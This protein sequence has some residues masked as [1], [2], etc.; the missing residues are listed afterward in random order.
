[1]WRPSFLTKKIL[2]RSQSHPLAGELVR[3]DAD[4]DDS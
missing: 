2:R 4:G 3:G 1:M